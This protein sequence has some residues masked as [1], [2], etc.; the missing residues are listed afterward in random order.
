MLIVEI[1]CKASY[2][3]FLLTVVSRAG[4]SHKCNDL[5][6]SAFTD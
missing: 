6:S 1:N 2:Q 5:C 3:K 4:C